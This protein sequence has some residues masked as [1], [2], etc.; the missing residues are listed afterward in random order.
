MRALQVYAPT[1]QRAAFRAAIDA[2]AGWVRRASPRFTEERAFQL[3]GLH[4]SNAS[5]AMIDTAGRALIAEQ[6]ADGGWS[7]LP[8]LESDAYATGQALASLA[9]SG[10][11][12]PA[13]AVYQRGVAFLVKTQLAD[14]S[15]FVP[16]RAIPIQPLFDAGFPHGPHA[17]ISAAATNWAVMALAPA[18][19][20][21]AQTAGR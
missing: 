4:W 19:V 9:Q 18:S 8:T 7:Q 20:A 11:L 5:K 10:A 12:M 16:T 14:G 13:T 3:M 1:A 21:R 2:A 17:F 15:W 6:R